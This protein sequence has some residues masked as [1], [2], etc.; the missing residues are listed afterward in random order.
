MKR[1]RLPP[2]SWSRHSISD[3]PTPKAR[4][5]IVYDVWW[6][7]IFELSRDRT[8]T[9]LCS[10]SSDYL[11]AA[12]AS[13]I[14]KDVFQHDLGAATKIRGRIVPAPTRTRVSRPLG[15]F[16]FIWENPFRERE[17]DRGRETV[18]RCCTA[19]S[20]WALPLCCSYK[21]TFMTRLT[22]IVL[23]LG[24][25]RIARSKLLTVQRPR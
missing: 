23:G 12:S 15:S 20:T 13:L 17:R 1:S 2:K 24:P 14:Y 25:V 21:L 7:A 5:A 10:Y 4:H 18:Y 3:Y 8:P 16:A 6:C 11:R 19:T 22:T 9:H